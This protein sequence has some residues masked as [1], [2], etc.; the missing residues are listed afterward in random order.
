MT[1]LDPISINGNTIDPGAPAVQ[2]LGLGKGN[3]ADS[4]YVLIQTE[5]VLNKAQKNDFS[6][7]KIAIKERV[8]DSTYLCRFEPT[9]LE[10]IRALDFVKWVAVYPTNF[11]VSSK[12]KSA[13]TESVSS[14]MAVLSTHP[15]MVD[16]VFHEGHTKDADVLKN[17]VAR[18]AHVDPN[19]LSGTDEKIRLTV[20]G[21][22]LES[23][24]QIDDVQSIVEVRQ[25]KLFNN[26]ARNI[27]MGKGGVT[28]LNDVTVDGVVFRGQDQIIAVADTGV[29]SDHPAFGTR[30]LTTFALGRPGKTDD[31]EGHGTHV[32]GSVLGNGVANGTDV[33]QGTAPEAQLV[34]QSVGD[35]SG[36]LDGIP[37]NLN[38]LFQQAYDAGARIHSDSWGDVAAAQPYEQ[39]ATE[40]DQFVYSHPNFV[41]C[42]V[43]VVSPST[44]RCKICLLS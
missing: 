16:V 22:Y 40:I 42:F 8:G 23:V 7:L 39:S 32:C 29:D 15:H 28:D 5:Q 13:P 11:V 10:P 21:R 3:A 1:R 41:I 4:N 43:C 6:R 2:A 12:L 31:T 14:T 35:A 17:D 33:I 19:G 34:M 24:A 26:I 36:G 30:I 25:N 20:Q 37:T 44:S 38:R 9:D 18:A 27:L